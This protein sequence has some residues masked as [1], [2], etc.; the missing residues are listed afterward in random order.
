MQPSNEEFAAA[1]RALAEIAKLGPKDGKVVKRLTQALLTCKRVLKAYRLRTEMHVTAWTAT[2]EDGKAKV[3]EISEGAQKGQ[4][5][6]VF[7]NEA[8]YNKAMSALN[9][10]TPTLEGELMKPFTFS[11]LFKDAEF[12]TLPDAEQLARLGPFFSEE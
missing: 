4:Q 12:K 10:E 1:E 7:T 6:I 9:K 3:R 2:D 11:E 8:E 5:A